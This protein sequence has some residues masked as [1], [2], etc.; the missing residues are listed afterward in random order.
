MFQEGV[1]PIANGQTDSA[2]VATGKTEALNKNAVPESN[3]PKP[4]EV[5]NT[6]VLRK[7]YKA[8]RQAVLDKKVEAYQ[9]GGKK[10]NTTNINVAPAPLTEP[11]KTPE[12]LKEENDRDEKLILILDLAGFSADVLPQLKEDLDTLQALLDD[13]E[14]GKTYARN[15]DESDAEYAKRLAGYLTKQV[16]VA[17]EEK[18]QEIDPKVLYR[19]RLLVKVKG[20][21]DKGDA[22]LA[23]MER[24]ALVK[25]KN[26]QE[27]LFGKLPAEVEGEIEKA[28]NRQKLIRDG[29]NLTDL[30]AVNEQIEKAQAEAD[31]TP[32]SDSET[33]KTPEE[34]AEEVLRKHAADQLKKIKGVHADAVDK[35]VGEDGKPSL[36]EV[37]FRLERVKNAVITGD[38]QKTQLLTMLGLTAA[39]ATKISVADFDT[40]DVTFKDYFKATIKNA[41]DM[42]L[43]QTN[44]NRLLDAFF[45]VDSG[46]SFAGN[47]AGFEGIEGDPVSQEAFKKLV[48]TNPQKFAQAIFDKRENFSR[49]GM[50]LDSDK[51]LQPLKDA[52][53]ATGNTTVAQ[54]NLKLALHYLVV[55]IYKKDF[56]R[57]VFTIFCKE[58]AQAAF[59]GKVLNGLEAEKIFTI[60]AKVKDIPLEG[61]N[62]NDLN[63]KWEEDFK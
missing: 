60:L 39:D 59:E 31:R 34:I 44:M 12:K 2:L 3:I 14:V 24:I 16:E 4:E 9:L 62:V 10:K 17:E 33:R 25:L 11:V 47:G 55:Q 63:E 23:N 45:A 40:E 51:F 32:A 30:Y 49:V 26:R 43:G 48:N 58:V 46:G 57:K 29:L 15:K 13:K 42:H 18:T 61:R 35:L 41:W 6:D 19:M 36:D 28:Q 27:A 7:E 37:L 50:P 8:P 52:I 21:L 54:E 5:S 20:F 56:G 1:R 53:N 22:Y 38:A